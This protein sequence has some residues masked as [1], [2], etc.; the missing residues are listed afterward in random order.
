V[1]PF[2]A[3]FPEFQLEYELPFDGERDVMVGRTYTRRHRARDIRRD[4]EH[5]ERALEE[6]WGMVTSH[7]G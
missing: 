7:R 5:T 3:K 1:E 4:A 2:T 6:Q